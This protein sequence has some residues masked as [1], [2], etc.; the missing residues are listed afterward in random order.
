M[1]EGRVKDLKKEIE[2]ANLIKK[3]KI[4]NKEGIGFGKCSQCGALDFACSCKLEIQGRTKNRS[5][6]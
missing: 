6:K 2:K 5:G 4:K 3:L 1:V